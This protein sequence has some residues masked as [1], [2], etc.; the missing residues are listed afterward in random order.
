MK[1]KWFVPAIVVAVIVVIV[2]AL[3]GTYNNLV[4]DREKVRTS[5]SNLDTTYQ[6]RTD[7]VGNLV[8]TV[9]GTSDF[10]QDTLTQ[11]TE[12]RSNVAGIKIDSNTSP[13]KLQAYVDAQN[14]LTGSLSRLIAVAENYPTLR[15]TEAY[16][17]LMVSLE[18]TENRIQIARSDYNE[19]AR[20][21]NTKLQTFPTGI[22]ANLFG[23]ERAVYFEAAPGSNTAPKVDFGSSK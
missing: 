14:Q 23:F 2:V 6:R 17:D 16:R 13:E 19:V 10:E 4:S 8:A 3:T 18:G 12:A 21:Y 7:L 5:L 11:V 9:K 1:S 20:P 15:S 22:I